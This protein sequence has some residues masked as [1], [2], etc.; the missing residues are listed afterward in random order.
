VAWRDPKEDLRRNF[1]LEKDALD[2]RVDEQSE[3]LFSGLGAGSRRTLSTTITALYFKSLLALRGI[4]EKT[5]GG[6]AGEGK[7]LQIDISQAEDY[8]R[9]NSLQA[10]Q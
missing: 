7:A 8:P 1:K 4:A 5:S 6:G 2:E 3:R 10:R 9:R